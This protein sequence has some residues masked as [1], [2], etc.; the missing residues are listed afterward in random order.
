M[1]TLNTFV[2]ICL[3]I[4]LAAYSQLVF[5]WRLS[6]LEVAPELFV[7]RAIY[8]VSILKDAY[9]FS[10]FLAA[11]LSSFVWM[12]VLS[13]LPLNVAFPFYYGGTFVAVY[14][15]SAI[16]LKEHISTNGLLG[17]VLVLVGLIVG[18]RT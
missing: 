17:A 5:K 6:G 15:L 2:Y 3:T 7:D 13:R 12:S 10:A 16:V 1:L 8:F 9:V 14:L 18:S 4:F 11:F